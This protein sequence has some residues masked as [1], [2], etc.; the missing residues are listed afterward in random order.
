[1]TEYLT[2]SNA[3]PEHPGMNF[4]LLREEGIKHIERLAGKLWTDYN[5]HD[6]GITILEQ[7]CYAITDLSY[8][9]NFEMKDLLAPVPGEN[10]KQFFSA[11]EIMTVNP[12]TINDYRQL[13]IDLD[14][15]K[16]A[17]LEPIKNSQP[18][19]YYD[20]MR[21]TLTFQASDITQEVNLNGLY[22]VM[23]E[24]AKGVSDEASLIEKITT[25]LQQHRNLCEDFASI[26]ILPIEEITIKAEIEIKEGFDVNQVMAEIYLEVEKFISPSLRFFTLQELL[27]QGKTPETI[28]EGFPLEHG[29][30]DQEQLNNFIKKDELYTSDLIRIILDIPGIKT[31]RTIAIGSNNSPKLELW[32]LA[33]DPNLTPQLKNIDSWQIDNDI[34]FYKGEI[35]CDID[36]NKTK[37]HLQLLQT[38]STELPSNT[39][40]Q[41]IPIPQGQYRE[42]SDYETIQNDFP[43]T[44]GIG[45]IGLPASV[46][47]QRKAQ[48]KQLQAYLMFFDQI[49]AT[50]FAQLEH[51]KDLFSFQS[52]HK[53]TYFS[54]DIS[55]IP[56]AKDIIKIDTKD[57]DNQLNKTDLERKNRFLNHLMAQ[58][59]EKFTDYSL[60]L[61][62]SIVAE[63]LIDNKI[64]F[65]QNYPQ[66]S[67]GR[68]KAFNY[69]DS[70]QL[71]DTDNVSGL[72]QRICSLLGIPYKRKTLAL[73]K[74]A[75]EIEGFHIIEH[76]LLRPSSNSNSE[77]NANFL[78]FGHQ[79]SEFKASTISPK[80]VTCVSVQHGLSQ[81]EQIQIFDTD[82]YNGIYVITNVQQDTFD[83]EIETGFIKS[84]T[85]QWIQ[86]NRPI[87]P[88]SFQISFIFPDWLTRFQNENFRKL[89]YNMIISEIPAHI[90]PYFHWLDKT[91]MRDFENDYQNWLNTIVDKNAQ[92]DI[93]KNT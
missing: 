22:R 10:R 19:I 76:I 33:L 9:L 16:N 24:K 42:L 7:L 64:N 56:G 68:G 80:I 59:C 35:P 6:P 30:I 67:A 27:E 36:L 8:R 29:F 82:H 17:W 47:P 18:P 1:M 5:T 92:P 91:K 53:E 54:S 41:D 63:N 4:A 62:D 84:E 83:I 12:L 28:F 2:I 60:L 13:L 85:G 79:I 14:G 77:D 15:V 49:L 55:S 71:W 38:Q 69:N 89:I 78:S 23:I 66:I 37:I 72:K 46:S 20:L 88:Y 21:H 11:R 75:D 65:L 39:Q 48:A 93:I 87:D 45:E 26:Q 51:T 50:Y 81:S 52:N 57:V 32:V 25:K 43:A 86:L 61:Y 70:S 58:F 40:I 34:I 31:V 44:Y 74:E 73:S 3:P 90:T